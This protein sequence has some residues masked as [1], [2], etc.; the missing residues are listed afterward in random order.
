MLRVRTVFAVAL[1]AIGVS[2]AA[3]AQQPQGAPRGPGGGRGAAPM[4]QVDRMLDSISLTTEQTAAVDALKKKYEPQ[5]VAMRQEMM[6]A[7]QNGGDMTAFRAKNQ[8]LMGKVE[9]D[10]RAILTKDQVAVL[11]KN[12]AAQE[13]RMREMQQRGGGRPPRA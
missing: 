9:A 11:E 10:L 12:K 8:E 5:V 3:Q 1:L 6:E 7:R 2:S 4:A 13:A